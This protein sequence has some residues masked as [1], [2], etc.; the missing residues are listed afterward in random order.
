MREILDK[1]LG[2]LM[3]ETR[4]GV[5]FF[6]IKSKRTKQRKI[7]SNIKKITYIRNSN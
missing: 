2:Y 6:S 3:G 5:L 4:K 7:K 1:G